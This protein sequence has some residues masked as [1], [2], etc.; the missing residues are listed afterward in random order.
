MCRP[1]CLASMHISTQH[2]PRA[3]PL[4]SYLSRQ[5]PGAHTPHTQHLPLAGTYTNL[6]A[7][8]PGTT[9]E[10]G[11][12]AA[13]ATN[14][15]DAQHTLY[16]SCTGGQNCNMLGS[17]EVCMTVSHG[18]QQDQ[19]AL[20]RLLA[21]PAAVLRPSQ[22]RASHL[23]PAATAPSL[24]P[25]LATIFFTPAAHWQYCCQTSASHQPLQAHPQGCCQAAQR[26]VLRCQACGCPVV[27]FGVSCSALDLMNRQ[28][29]VAYCLRC[30]GETKVCWPSCCRGACTSFCREWCLPH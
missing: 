25:R 18:G 24:R 27:G 1:S 6:V 22:P 8:R 3:L 21:P 28:P 12:N 7:C 5:L 9:L 30:A 29:S 17:K 13:A 4:A 15:R 10:G 11:C 20:G 23:P 2:Q 16:C 14:P 19:A 26:G